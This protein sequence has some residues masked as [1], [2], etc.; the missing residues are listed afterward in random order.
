MTSDSTRYLW[1]RPVLFG[2]LTQVLALLTALLVVTAYATYLAFRARGAPSQLLI[3]Q[4][5]ASSAPWV[6]AVAGIVLAFVFSLRL[7]KR[8]PRQPIALGIGVGL[9]SSVFAAIAVLVL[10][11]HVGLYS[12]LVAVSFLVASWVGAVLGLSRT[13]AR[14]AV[15]G[16]RSR[17]VELGGW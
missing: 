5:A 8:T 3:N 11:S 12:A 14:G 10:H 1:L 15:A 2:L 16:G 17:L 9:S 7:A 13:S 4:F 6:M